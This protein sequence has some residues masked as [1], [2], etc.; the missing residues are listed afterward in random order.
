MKCILEL[1]NGV[2]LIFAFFRILIDFLFEYFKLLGRK[3]K[4]KEE[5]HFWIEK[6]KKREVQLT[7]P[8]YK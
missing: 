7:S 3:L 6:S 5:E 2:Q 1:D 8:A 4:I